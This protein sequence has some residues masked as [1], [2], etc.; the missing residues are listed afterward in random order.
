MVVAPGR[1]GEQDVEAGHLGAPGEGCGL[2]EPLAVLHGL[3]G[4]HHREGLVR[5]EEAVPSGERVA[6][7]PA[8]TVVLGEHLHHPP[9]TRECDIVVGDLLHE[10]TV[11]DG[12]DISEPIA[13]GLI[14][15]EQAE[16]VG[17][18]GVEVA[19]Q[20][21]QPAGRL[22]EGAVV[23]LDLD[24]I[25]AEVG[26]HQIA[27]ETSTVGVRG[28]A[29]PQVTRGAE[30]RG[31]S[32]ES[33]TGIEELLGPVGPHPRLELREV[34]RILPDPGERHLV[35]TERALDQHA[36]DLVGAGPALRGA[37]HD[38]RPARSYAVPGSVARGG[39]D[40]LDA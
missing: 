14:G 38:H 27:G 35:G 6:L 13:G 32:G 11:G 24:G 37:K 21:A 2:L 5:R 34:L 17:V 26:H 25:V 4:T 12:E 16:C 36:V 20:A 3:R 23:H 22:G 18:R 15:T 28:R 7:Q 40:R 29:H 9:V 19:Q 30:R 10:G 1:R 8:V 33:T 39:L 31:R